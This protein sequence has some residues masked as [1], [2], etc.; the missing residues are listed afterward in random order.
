MHAMRRL[1]LLTVA[2]L[3]AFALVAPVALA[4]VAGEGL[5]GETSDTQ[6]TDA[7]FVL[8]LF[9]PIFVGLASLLQHHLE[10]RK[11]ARDDARKARTQSPV[12]RGGW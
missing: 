7:G 10:K 4:G 3:I 12:W 6:V 5:L 8:I 1:I 9:F 2:N 11:H